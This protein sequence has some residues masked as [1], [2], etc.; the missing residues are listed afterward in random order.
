MVVEGAKEFKKFIEGTYVKL[1]KLDY[2]LWFGK[3]IVLA[4]S[5]LM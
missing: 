1:R 3:S 2:L 4:F 5:H